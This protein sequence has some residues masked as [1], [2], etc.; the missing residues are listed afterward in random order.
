MSRELVMCDAW[1]NPMVF[2]GV[3]LRATLHDFTPWCVTFDSVL[4][5]QLPSDHHPGVGIGFFRQ[6]EWLLK[7][8]SPNIGLLTD[9]SPTAPP[10]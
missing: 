4:D 10:T 7:V 8:A 1:L 3:L 9:H 6:L 5:Y 2:G